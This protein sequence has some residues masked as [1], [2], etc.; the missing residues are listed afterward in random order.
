M[1]SR[2]PPKRDKTLAGPSL[3]KF[4]AKYGHNLT[5]PIVLHTKDIQF[6]NGITYLPLYMAPLL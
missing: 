4:P 1:W 2:N 5:S 6:A 3:D